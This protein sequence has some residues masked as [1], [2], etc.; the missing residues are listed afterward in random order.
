[1]KTL[2]RLWEF[3]FD[4]WKIEFIEEKNETWVKRTTYDEI[5]I[6]GT[7]REYNRTFHMYRYTNKFDGSV[8]I[9]KKEV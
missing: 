7:E 3:L 2:H 1:M 9:V 5:P 8:K 6:P 4:R